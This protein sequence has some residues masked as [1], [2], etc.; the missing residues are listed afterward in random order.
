MKKLVLVTI[1]LLLPM[2]A[3]A[4][5][6]SISNQ[7]LQDLLQKKVPIV[8]VRTAPEWQQT[9]VIEG[10]QLLTFFDEKGGYDAPVFL[11]ALD[12]I[13]SKNEPVILICRSGRR[14]GII[15]NFLSE[16]VGYSQVYNV[17]KGIRHW[18]SESLPTVKP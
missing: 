4:E 6:I 10:S 3:M 9:G 11:E 13:A 8:D 1:L 5:V 12:K 17:E 14:T 18:I 15:S 7:Q 16:Q 2:S